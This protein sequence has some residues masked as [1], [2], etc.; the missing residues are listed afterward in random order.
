MKKGEFI[1]SQ[2]AMGYR[3]DPG[4]KHKLII[5]EDGAEIVR[6]IFHLY[7]MGES[8]RHIAEVFNR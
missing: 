2:P 6:R 3:R 7:A 8:A 1:G 4:N 5:E